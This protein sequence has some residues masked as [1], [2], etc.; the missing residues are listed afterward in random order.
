M[1]FLW[2]KLEFILFCVD[3]VQDIA[4]KGLGL[5]YESCDENLRAEMLDGLLDQLNSG[6]RTV[7]KVTD[8]TKLFEEGQL[9]KSPTGY[10]TNARASTV[11]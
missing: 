1:V 11:V 5:V 9:G 3:I 7:Q 2:L 10:V 6:R 4:S 8:D